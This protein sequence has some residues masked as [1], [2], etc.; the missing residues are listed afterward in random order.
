MDKQQI[1]RAIAA[2]AAKGELAFPT[3][4]QVALRVMQALD[5]PDCQIE[6]AAKLVQAEPLLAAR[7]VAMSNSVAFNRAAHLLA[8]CQADPYRR[9]AGIRVLPLIMGAGLKNQA[10]RGPFATGARDGQELRPSGQA[11]HL[12]PQPLNLLML[13]DGGEPA[14]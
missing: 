5:N 8:G 11:P 12:G 1:F 10:R 2:D 13:G 14:A 7:V 6:V 4:A 3:G 9:F